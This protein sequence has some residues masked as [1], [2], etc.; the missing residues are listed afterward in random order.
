MYV[1]IGCCDEQAELQKARGSLVRPRVR[2]FPIFKK[3]QRNT[4]VPAII[5]T[6]QTGVRL[7]SNSETIGGGQ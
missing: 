1:P 2:T 5:P 4:I 7:H 3:E 6:S